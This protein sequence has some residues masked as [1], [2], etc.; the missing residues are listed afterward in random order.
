MVS[1]NGICCCF[2]ARLR[3][4]AAFQQ[5]AAADV[6]RRTRLNAV[7]RS[8][9]RTFPPHSGALRRQQ[10]FSV[11]LAVA[12]AVPAVVAVGAWCTQLV[13][14]FPAR[15]AAAGMTALFFMGASALELVPVTVA[16]VR[17]I[18]IPEARKS[19]SYALTVIGIVALLP[20]LATYLTVMLE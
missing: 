9:E 11:L 6:R 20:A 18:R 10:G 13:M 15:T 12:L 4:I 14:K 8:H 3:L 5:R 2:D 7:V 1:G 16:I 17:L 19:W